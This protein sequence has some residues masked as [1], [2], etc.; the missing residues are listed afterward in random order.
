MV[1]KIGGSRKDWVRVGK[2]GNDRGVRREGF[3]VR[4]KEEGC[5]GGDNVKSKVGGGGGYGRF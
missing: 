3:W 2:G 5:V 4:G 1:L